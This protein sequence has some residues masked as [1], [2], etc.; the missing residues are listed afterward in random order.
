MKSPRWPQILLPVGFT[1]ILVA[2]FLIWLPQPI[3][4]LSFIGLEMGEWVKFL[5][6]V[7][8]G[9]ISAN[10]NYFYIPPITLGMMMIAWT[11]TWPNKRWQTWVARGLAVAVAFL[12]FPSVEAILDEPASEWLL[13][14]ILVM[15][16]LILAA[17]CPLFKRLPPGILIKGSWL[18]IMLLGLI[19]A[20]FP[21]WAYLAVRGPVGDLL[22]LA[23]GIGPGV[24]LNAAG[25]ILLVGTVAYFLVAGSDRHQDEL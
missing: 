5:P 16:V 23:I 12:A 3:V 6:Q 15:V 14:V 2:Y 17:L 24:W 1:T 4:G 25:H 7:R 10:R 13:R 19:G 11:V 8:L 21:T 20:I 9:E 22:R 18:L